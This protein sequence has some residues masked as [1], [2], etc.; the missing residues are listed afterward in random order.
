MRDATIAAEDA[1]RRYQSETQTPAAPFPYQVQRQ[2]A[3]PTQTLR[4]ASGTVGPLQRIPE[5][6]SEGSSG[7]AAATPQALRIGGGAGHTVNYGALPRNFDPV[8]GR[9]SENKGASRRPSLPYV[10][11]PLSQQPSDAGQKGDFP[12]PHQSVAKADDSLLST[13]QLQRRAS[14]DMQSPLLTRSASS[15]QQGHSQAQADRGERQPWDTPSRPRVLPQATRD[16][17]PT[18][19]VGLR[20]PPQRST[21]Q[22]LPL[23]INKNRQTQAHAVAAALAYKTEAASSIWSTSSS[24]SEPTPTASSIAAARERNAQ[25]ATQLIPIQLTLPSTFSSSSTLTLGQQ[26]PQLQTIGSRFG[27]PPVQEQRQIPPMVVSPEEVASIKATAAPFAPTK[28]SKLSAPPIRSDSND[29]SYS[30]ETVALP[31]GTQVPAIRTDFQNMKRISL[32]KTA[33]PSVGGHVLSRADP[34]VVARNDGSS[35]TIYSPTPQTLAAA[36][37]G[38][39]LQVP[40]K[41]EQRIPSPLSA[42]AEAPQAPQIPHALKFRKSVPS[43]GASETQP[44]Q[45]ANEGKDGGKSTAATTQAKSDDTDVRKRENA[46]LVGFRGDPRR[47]TFG[48][49]EPSMLEEANRKLFVYQLQQ[50]DQDAR[51]KGVGSSR[52]PVPSIEKVEKK[53]ESSAPVATSATVPTASSTA[54]PTSVVRRESSA[55]QRS[56]RDSI[57]SATTAFDSPTKEE[58]PSHVRNATGPS[59]TTG[60]TKGVPGNRGTARTTVAPPSD[61]PEMQEPDEAPAARSDEGTEIDDDAEVTY[62]SSFEKRVPFIIDTFA[63]DDEGNVT[64]GDNS[65]FRFIP[66]SSVKAGKA[67][68]PRTRDTR[69]SFR[70]NTSQIEQQP[71]PAS[72]QHHRTTPACKLC[73]RAGFDCAQNITAGQNTAGRVAFQDFVAAGGLNAF[74]IRMRWRDHWEVGEVLRLKK[75]WGGIMWISWGRLHLA[76]RR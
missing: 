24:E 20:A 45:P 51:V 21:V 35:R 4:H 60:I 7:E 63:K 68:R 27:A 57:G 56:R 67:R 59:G 23:A 25:L 6:V 54:E 58:F 39:S 43:I 47:N 16:I 70:S 36:R 34:K 10:F 18:T 71:R 66:I 2:A 26:Q 53:A 61:V 62:D 19:P 42:S 5:V 55:S 17:Q 1:L 40:Q 30:G 3:P 49:L 22:T 37:R 64:A 32:P 11:E 29:T 75:H 33:E 73:F 15:F 44:S 48:E 9:K 28:P 50:L 12:N 52:K 31:D 72:R 69:V 14:Q 8:T 13:A 41:E 65:A 46:E 74:S 76:S 38:T